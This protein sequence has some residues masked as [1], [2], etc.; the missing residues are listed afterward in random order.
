MQKC[1][2]C[3]K[4]YEDGAK[5]CR[6]CGSILDECIEPL[7]EKKKTPAAAENS[8]EEMLTMANA[9]DERDWVCP[10]CKKNVPGNFDVCWNCFA[11]RDGQFDPEFAE[12]AAADRTANQEED[13]IEEILA[14]SAHRKQPD[15]LCM[16]CG[17]DKIVRGARVLDRRENFTSDLT[18]VVYGEPDALVFKD[19]RYGTL[20]AEICGRC[21][22]VEL[23][24]NNPAE[25]YE[26]YLNSRK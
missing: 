17:S 19:R 11:G 6:T 21:G 24:V 23:L 16:R 4:T 9:I 3:E 13:D 8:G 20:T 7:I 15:R 2:K 12:K 5:I 1:P 14:A 18:V 25:L 26:H 22:H 10:Q